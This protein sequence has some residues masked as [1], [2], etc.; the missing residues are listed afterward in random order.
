MLH[1]RVGNNDQ[2]VAVFI[3]W[4][5]SKPVLKCLEGTR[6][7]LKVLLCCFPLMVEHPILNIKFTTFAFKLLGKA[8]VVSD[9]HIDAIIVNWIDDFPMEC[10]CFGLDIM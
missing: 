8:N 9:I 6:H 7:F 3:K 4:I 10:F 2:F 1:S 5:L